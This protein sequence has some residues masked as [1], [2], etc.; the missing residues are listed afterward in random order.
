VAWWLN[1]GVN[2]L[3]KSRKTHFLSFRPRI[4]CGI[5]SSRNP[6][7]QFG[8]EFLDSGF[9]RSDDF[10]RNHQIL[11]RLGY[12]V[13]TRTSSIEALELFRTKPDQFD[14]VIT[15]MTMPKMMGDK[16]AKE[17]MKVRPDI[18]IVLC[19]GFSQRI[20]EEK[21]KGMGIKA[22][23]MKPFVMRDLAETVRK[24]LDG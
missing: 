24:G 21:A 15:D 22:F 9:H 20:S 13:T 11:E 2:E 12:E 4:K 17:L 10:L 23:S 14:L 3:V 1:K 8:T 19:T 7:F 18:P 5:N 16:L 6:V